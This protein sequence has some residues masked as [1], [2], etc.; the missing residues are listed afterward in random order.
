[1]SAPSR[2]FALLNNDLFFVNGDIGIMESD[3]QHV[4]DTIAAC[5][6]WWKQNPADGVGVIQYLNSA[7][8]EQELTR[9]TIIQLKSDGYSSIPD[10]LLDASGSLNLNPEAIKE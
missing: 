3:V 10:F 1:M 2:D 8:Q 6:G 5:P 9:T 7:Q 4:T